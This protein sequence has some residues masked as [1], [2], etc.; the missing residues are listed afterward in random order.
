MTFGALWTPNSVGCFCL[1][2]SIDGVALEE[3]Y[4]VDVKE[5]GVPPPPLKSTVTKTQAPNK[6]RK[7]V[8]KNSAGLRIRSH[9]TLQSEQVGIVKMLGVV[10]FIDE[11]IYRI[12]SLSLYLKY[13]ISNRLKM[14][15]V[16]GFAY[17]L[18]RF[19]NI[20]PLAGIRSKHGVY[21]TTNTLEKL[22]CIPS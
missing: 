21:N 13:V 4:R 12:L 10:S 6:L 15:M 22:Y 19:D 14:M 17:P 20:V 16:F 7:F 8:A 11:V 5:A 1:T 9:P 3:V 18:N 2:I